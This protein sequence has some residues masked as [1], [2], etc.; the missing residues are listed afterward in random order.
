MMLTT[1]D[2]YSLEC[3]DRK[4]VN[5]VAFDKALA[6]YRDTTGGR[7]KTDASQIVYWAERKSTDFSPKGDYVEVFGLLRDRQVIGFALAFYIPEQKLYVVDHVAITPSARSM[8]AFD[9]F[10]DLIEGHV[11]RAGVDVEYGV[12]EVSMDMNDIWPAPGSADT[13]L[14]VLMEPEVCH[15]ETEVYTRVQA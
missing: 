1:R 2:Q 6:I 9:R 14:G 4:S 5:S 10:C 8:T 7:V 13:E 12:A 15:G 3:F 11:K